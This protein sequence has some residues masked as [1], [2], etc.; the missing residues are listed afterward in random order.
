M[1][2]AR[3]QA[4]REA[5]FTLIEMLIA[6]ILLASLL[7]VVSMVLMK[8][9]GES[10]RAQQQRKAAQDMR[11]TM[12]Q[13]G[14]DLR[15]AR[16]PDRDPRFVGNGNDLGGALLADQPLK[17]QLPGQPTALQ[18]DVRDIVEATSTSFM[19]RADAIV[20][21][22]VECVRYAVDPSTRSLTRTVHN[23]IQASRSCD[24]TPIAGQTKVLVQAVR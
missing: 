13:F 15:V 3:A 1:S 6:M 24:P 8:T 18:L 10:G 4:R 11:T 2:G 17:V 19:F 23:Y 21:G 7:V 5:G 12:S 16:S 22:A 14:N 20:G 9:F